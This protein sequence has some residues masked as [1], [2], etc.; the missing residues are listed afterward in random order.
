L[1]RCHNLKELQ[2]LQKEKNHLKI[3]QY[4]IYIYNKIWHSNSVNI[5]LLSLYEM[6][7][8]IIVPRKITLLAAAERMNECYSIDEM[9]RVLS[10][11]YKGEVNDINEVGI[12]SLSERKEK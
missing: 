10:G 9:L 11:D 6:L 8:N 4:I 12:L 7:L 3:T 5:Q 1:T 2:K